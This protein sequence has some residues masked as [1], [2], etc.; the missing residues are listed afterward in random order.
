MA[1]IDEKEIQRIQNILDK[2]EKEYPKNMETEALIQDTYVRI[3]NM[4]KAI[5]KS[6]FQV[7]KA[8]TEELN[9]FAT[10]NEQMALEMKDNIDE[11]L[12]ENSLK[13]WQS[14]LQLKHKDFAET[15][16]TMD[17]EF[18]NNN[19]K[20]NQCVEDC[21]ANSASKTNE[22][23]EKSLRACMARHEGVFSEITKKF[24]A[25]FKDYEKKYQ[26]YL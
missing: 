21:A 7:C 15:L 12:F 6:S 16:H 17:R 20:M 14:C 1:N 2:Q 10:F 23:I 25:T 19:N 9:K 8:E 4:D 5:I 18:N 26:K 11:R 22:E 3:S 13:K 24:N